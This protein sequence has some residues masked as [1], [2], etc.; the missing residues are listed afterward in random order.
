MKRSNNY[1]ILSVI[2][3]LSFTGCATKMYMPLSQVT[4]AEILEPIAVDFE[5]NYKVGIGALSYTGIGLAAAGGWFAGRGISREP[6][7]EYRKGDFI[8]S[9]GLGGGALVLLL[10]EVL[11]NARKS[12]RINNA[13]REALLNAASERYSEE[14][15]DIR[16]IRFTY[17]RALGGKTY[18]YKASGTIIKK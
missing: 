15:I 4:N 3:L 18:L 8:L 13:A 14:D 7:D 10:I 17:I 1:V 2:L 16:D 6:S 12:A 9:A 11:V 5:S